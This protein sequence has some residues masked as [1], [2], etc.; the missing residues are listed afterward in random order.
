MDSS[1]TPQEDIKTS[2]S[3]VFCSKSS[4]F[5]A[6]DD[7]NIIKAGEIIRNGGLVS[8]PTETVYGLGANALDADAATSIFTTKER[9][10]TDPLIVHIYQKSDA[11]E[12]I[13]EEEWIIK[14]FNSLADKFWPGPLTCVM[15]ANQE[16]IS[17]VITS[18]TGFVGIRCPNHEIALKLIKEAERP[19]AAPSANKF[20]HVSPTKAEHVLNDFKENHVF[21]LDGGQCDFGIESTVVKIYREHVEDSDKIHIKLLILRRGGISQKLLTKEVNEYRLENPDLVLTV[22]AIK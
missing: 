1:K 9:P 6:S 3:T 18:G 2:T 22:D 13:D 10:M 19:I 5:D 8:F 7:E 15:K 4:V 12:L 21:I 14:L 20:G 16:K 11:Y 17:P